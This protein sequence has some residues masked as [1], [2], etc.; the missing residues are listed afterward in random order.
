MPHTHTHTHT[1]S[2]PPFPPL[3]LSLPLWI[4]AH[5][6]L[7]KMPEAAVP[8]VNILTNVFLLFSLSWRLSIIISSILVFFVMF[9][10]WRNYYTAVWQKRYL[11]MVRFCSR[12]S[13]VHAFTHTKTHTCSFVW[14]RVPFP[15]ASVSV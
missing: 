2:L 8:I 12:C 5:R 4:T 15:C 13:H 14:P 11:D 9:T 6:L 7:Q 1:L 3:S 10:I